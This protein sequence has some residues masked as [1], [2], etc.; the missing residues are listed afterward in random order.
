MVAKDK[1]IGVVVAGGSGKRMGG[2]IRKQFLEIQ[3]KPILIHTLEKFD[4]SSGV[5]GVILVVPR[6]DIETS[7]NLIS[8]WGIRKVIN[9]IPGGDERQDSVRNGLAVVPEDVA[10]VVIHD[11]VRPFISPYKIDEL[12][13]EVKIHGAVIPVIP[14]SDTIKR[15]ENDQVTETMNREILM[16]V[17]TPQCFRKDWILKAYQRAY[18]DGFMQTDDAVLVER[19]GYIV[20]TIPGEITNI[21]ITTSWDLNI[22]ETISK[23]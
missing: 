9:F 7:R 20:H 15:I 3:G 23:K 17:Q 5:E 11:G 22:A 19:L 10:F 2:T 4:Q 12:V 13:K 18:Q 14:V 8:H 16:L 21:K 6:E 1:S